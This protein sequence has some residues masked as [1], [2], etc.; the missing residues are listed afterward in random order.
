MTEIKISSI[1]YSPKIKILNNHIITFD[2]R[3][4]ILYDLKGAELDNIKTRVYV[5]HEILD[6]CKI[7]NN[8]FI[9]M[10]EIH[11]LQIAI[12]KNRLKIKNKII[13]GNNINDCLYI[14]KYNLFIVSNNKNFIIFDIY[15]KDT[16]KIGNIEIIPNTFKATNLMKINE[17]LL[18]AYGQIYISLYKKKLGIKSYELISKLKL[19][20]ILK[21][22]KLDNKTFVSMDNNNNIFL[23]NNKKMKIYQKYFFF[24]RKNVIDFIYVIKSNIYIHKNNNLFIFKFFKKELILIKLLKKNPLVAFNYLLNLS[25]ENYFPYLKEKIKIN[26]IKNGNY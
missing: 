15:D 24:D 3:N 8:N 7:N 14:K 17:N 12:I 22:L 26:C 23:I 6:I 20:K 9:A 21:L 18:V 13:I 19:H 5:N 10:T 4:I 11:L 2:D 25:I 16:F 1:K